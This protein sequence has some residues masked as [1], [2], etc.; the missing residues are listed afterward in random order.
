MEE[1]MK[2]VASRST[3]IRHVA[4]IALLFGMTQIPVAHA[5]SQDAGAKKLLKSMSDYVASQKSISMA[6]DSDIEV[7][8]SELQKIQFASSGQQL[9]ISRPDKVHA[10]RTGGHADPKF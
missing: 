9:Q 7:I 5:Q 3:I 4:V 1:A 10:S 2:P 8:T 6:Y